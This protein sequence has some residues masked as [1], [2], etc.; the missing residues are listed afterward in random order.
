MCS[1]DLGSAL[2][3]VDRRNGVAI[4]L[5]AAWAALSLLAA[6]DAWLVPRLA[7]AGVLLLT[8][9]LVYLRRVDRVP[10]PA[11]I[12]PRLRELLAAA[13]PRARR[14]LTPLAA[15]I[16]RIDIDLRRLDLALSAVGPADA[17]SHALLLAQR[18]HLAEERAS[19]EDTLAGVAARSVV[20]AMDRV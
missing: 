7:A 5:A 3:L 18:T 14:A 19:L 1:S 8:A 15:R 13:G 4:F 12:A 17:P 20:Q 9:D 10:D 2:F 11:L 16:H 6:P